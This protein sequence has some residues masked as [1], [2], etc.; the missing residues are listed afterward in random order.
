MWARCGCRPLRGAV[1]GR[2]AVTGCERVGRYLW[3][4]R[5]LAVACGV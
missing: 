4:V 1:V 5:S 2:R 3:I